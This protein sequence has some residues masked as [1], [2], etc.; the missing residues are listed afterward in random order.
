M[1]SFYFK[2]LLGKNI[3]LN[4]AVVALHKLWIPSLAD[5]CLI[6]HFAWWRQVNILLFLQAY[7][8]VVFYRTFSCLTCSHFL[9]PRTLMAG[10]FPSFTCLCS[11]SWPTLTT[12]HSL[13]MVLSVF[14]PSAFQ[15][16]KRGEMKARRVKYRAAQKQLELEKQH[17]L[18]G[19][20]H[21]TG[22]T[23]PTSARMDPRD[24][25]GAGTGGKPGPGQVGPK[26]GGALD[27][28]L[29]SLDKLVELEKRISSLEKSNVYDD[30]RS[31]KQGGAAS[32]TEDV[33]RS[34][35]RRRGSS[36]ATGGAPSRWRNSAGRPAV[37]SRNR[38]LSFSKQTTEATID[39]PSQT[40][41]S[42]RVRR[43]PGSTAED[44]APLKRR[45]GG[46]INSK[47]GVGQRTGVGLSSS[48]ARGGASTF[49]TQL[50]DVHRHPRA[51]E[52]QSGGSR[53][54]VGEKKRIE[55]K[56]KL[57]GDRAEAERI[58]R[59][60]RIIREWMQRKR[61]AAVTGNRQR[62]SSVLSRSGG[63]PA[64]GGEQRRRRM[65]GGGSTSG[66]ARDMR[67][68]EFRDIRAHYAKRTERLRRDLS[69]G[70]QGPARAFLAG[71]RTVTV[72]RPRAARAASLA[73]PRPS[74][75]SRTNPSL[76]CGRETS[77]T[78]AGPM[79]HGQTRTLEG[80]GAR[81]R[82]AGLA[83]GGTGLRA[84]RARRQE[85]ASVGSYHTQRLQGSRPQR[86]TV[87]PTVRGAAGRAGSCS[88]QA[89]GVPTVGAGS[90]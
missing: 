20:L 13:S 77:R 57:A 33:S 11:L 32:T 68:Q 52:H 41:Y 28:V 46:D 17:L 58:A 79:R 6:L 12:Y 88:G 1:G 49:L 90:W 63:A 31:T 51:V 61:A 50:P 15:I 85:P 5:R 38:R 18:L 36:R 24:G 40:Y 43:K 7:S 30:F 55:A 42:V 2:P 67:L 34:I 54:A 23:G 66:A 3:L 65:G 37:G 74:R 86:S 64:A 25:A 16:A 22:S 35:G 39:I 9:L 10:Y 62:K 4:T 56:R 47:S 14:T 60:D 71:T 73:P 84:A 21:G 69:R 82:R 27:T 45:S 72:A 80:R 59:Q 75:M 87:L 29:G 26:P 19:K 70:Q 76:Q 53:S 81:M 48:R 89:G 44:S 83:V 78:S 8:E